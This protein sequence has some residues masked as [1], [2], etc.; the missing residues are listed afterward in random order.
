MDFYKILQDRPVFLFLFI[1]LLALSCFPVIGQEKLQE[2]V[3]VIAVEIPVRVLKKGQAVRNLTKEDFELFENGVQQKITAFDVVSRKISS[4]GGTSPEGL[5][6]SPKKRLFI[7]I[8]NIFDYNDEVGDGID[9]FFLNVFR[10]GDQIIILTEDR[11][12]NIDIKKNLSGMV[13]DLKETLQKYK[14]IS[15]METTKAFRQLRYEADRVMNPIGTGNRASDLIR[16]FDNYIRIWKDY[17]NRFISPDTVLYQSIISRVKQM[18]G[19]KWALCFLQR[20]LF[21]RL[22]NAGRLSRVI[23]GIIESGGGSQ[24][25]RLVRAKQAELQQNLDYTSTFPTQ[26]LN[27]LFMEANITFH[28]IL[29]K[30]VGKIM[31]EDFEMGEVAQDYEECFKQISRSTGGY[32]TFSNKV[33]QALEEAAEVED[34]HYLLVYSPKEN[35]TNGQRK[36]KI[37]VKQEG[38]KIVHVENFRALKSPPISISGFTSGKKS[39][40]FDLINYALEKFEGMLTGIVDVKIT[41]F[42]E[43]S[44]KVFDQGKTLSLVKKDTH[45]ALNFDALKSGRFYIIVQVID[46][47]TNAVDVFSGNIKF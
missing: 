15:T 25:S 28:L 6:I 19:E 14:S 5:K 1:F 31:A 44:N 40:S 35:Q 42:D 30:P 8:F 27:D 47:I 7:L 4:L 43:R 36:I 24:W 9:H 23:T 32:M 41:V 29:M 22:Q 21:P 33:T 37:K 46:R 16:F 11:L 34:F 2:E 45:V 18:D 3:T 17:K 39:I 20:E 12:L 13:N 10:P 38:V 26:L